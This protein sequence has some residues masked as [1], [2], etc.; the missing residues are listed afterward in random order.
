MIEALSVSSAL[1][2]AISAA[3]TLFQLLERAKS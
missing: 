3:L 2:G 1:D